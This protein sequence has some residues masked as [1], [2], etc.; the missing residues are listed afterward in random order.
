MA[1]LFEAIKNAY[2]KMRE[3]DLLTGFVVVLVL[4]VMWCMWCMYTKEGILIADHQSPP[5]PAQRVDSTGVGGLIRFTEDSST[6]R[7]YSNPAANSAATLDMVEGLA[8]NSAEPPVFYGKSQELDAY[9]RGQVKEEMGHV[10][11]GYV[12]R[13]E[14]MGVEDKLQ[15]ALQGF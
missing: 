12:A 13:S 3:N 2:D 15:G 14:F 11:S 1:G 5:V 7:G 10:G 9:N 4:V 6:N 8:A